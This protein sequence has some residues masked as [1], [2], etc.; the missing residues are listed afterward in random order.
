MILNKQ[1]F[2]RFK[3][4]FFYTISFFICLWILGAFFYLSYANKLVQIPAAIIV[5]TCLFYSF[6]KFNKKINL[7]ILICFI[8]TVYAFSFFDSPRNDRLWVPD[9]QFMP[10]I[11]IKEN[12]V[13]IKNFRNCRYRGINDFDVQWETRIFDIEKLIGV[14][15][16]VEPFADWRGLAHTFLSFSFSDGE[17]VSISVE[18]RKEKNEEYSVFAG[19][20]WNYEV[21][22]II[23]DEKDLIGL[24]A[25]IRKD[26][27]YLFP[28][29]AKKDQVKKLFLSMVERTAKL[30]EKPEYY[31]T[32]FNTCSTNI[33]RHLKENFDLKL[34]I[35][36]RIIFPGYA[37]EAAFE[38]NLI[39]TDQKL[40]EARKTFLINSRSEFIEDSKAWSQQIRN[41]KK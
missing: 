18:V 6:L 23:G 27:V 30:G 24:R 11:S 33:V 5:A 32:L 9:Q 13:T 20:Y 17:Y 35:D 14:D 28:I 38:L 41:Y 39:D 3:N 1:L 25:N 4:Y 36:Y 37:D 31:N 29:K 22:Y 8:V 7:K 40:E 19:I 16:I 10:T 34:G 2:D 21:I 12:E 15:F 26:P